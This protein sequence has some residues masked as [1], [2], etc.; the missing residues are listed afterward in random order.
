MKDTF[1][2]RTEWYSSIEELPSKDKSEILDAIFLYHLDRESEINLTTPLS[3]MCW[4]FIKPTIDYHNRR[5]RTSVENGKKGGAPKGNTNAKKQPENNL[6]Q[7]LVNLEQPKNNLTVTDTVTV[8]DIDID[9]VNEI[10]TVTGAVNEF[11]KD[12][13]QMVMINYSCS[14]EEAIEYMMNLRDFTSKKKEEFISIF[15]V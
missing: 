5:Y 8:T 6:K 12:D 4:N 7:P 15:D 10:D 3:K 2:L 11:D 9:T 13:I 14:E 1:V